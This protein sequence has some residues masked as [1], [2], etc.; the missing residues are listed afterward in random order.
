M[1]T[2]H[3]PASAPP[4]PAPR[5]SPF[6]GRRRSGSVRA[7]ALTILVLA[8]VAAAAASVA[9]GARGVTLADITAGM[10][11]ADGTLAEAAVAKRVPR[12]LLAVVAGAALGVSGALLQGLTRNPLADPGIFGITNGAAL[13]VVTGMTFFGMTSPHAY[14]WA[15]LLGAGVTAVFVYAV[16]SLGRG[17]ATP[18]KLALA[19]AAT[20]VA[21]TSLVSA[22]VLPH[23]AVM[24][25]FRFWQIGGV[26]GAAFDTLARV[27]PFLLTGFVLA[28]VSAR[29]LNALA[30][31]DE[32]A[33]GLGAKAGRTRIVA[34]LAAVLLCGAATAA[35]GPI[36]FVGLVVPH[37]CRMVFGPDHRWLLPLTALAGAVLLTVS[38]VAGRLIARP[39]ELEVGIV[40]ALI[41]APFFIVIV[42]RMRVRAL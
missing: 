42:R 28:L 39:E 41:G 11:G 2:L 36:A 25:A 37:M 4:R 32:M 12:T 1:S 20:S 23:A 6:A 9:F 5:P 18:L 30:L 40:T 17:G 29:G 33:R 14:I 7:T 19:G 10:T 31:G 26:G 22:V 35:A 8:L 15:A 34:A 3:A 27:A 21:L 16:G 13:A 38:D 24:D